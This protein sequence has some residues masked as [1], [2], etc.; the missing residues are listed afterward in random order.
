MSSNLS[1]ESQEAIEKYMRELM[2]EHKHTFERVIQRV[3]FQGF[4][5]EKEIEEI[6]L[7]SKC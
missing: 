2:T 7:E 5:T 3:V 6:I 1:K 4:I